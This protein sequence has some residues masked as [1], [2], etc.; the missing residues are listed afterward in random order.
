[1]RSHTEL[2]LIDGQ[3]ISHLPFE[4][5]QYESLLI[6]W[7]PID[8]RIL[9]FYPLGLTTLPLIIASNSLHCILIRN[10]NV[11]E[12]LCQVLDYHADQ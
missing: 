4:F 5:G 10:P 3:Y 12:A 11:L 7:L 6:F 2:Y 9:Y 1:M 8:G